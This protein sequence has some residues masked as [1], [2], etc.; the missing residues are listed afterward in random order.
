MSSKKPR[1]SNRERRRGGAPTPRASKRRCTATRA[2][3]VAEDEAAV[4]DDETAVDD[5][6]SDA[7]DAACNDADATEATADASA[8][9]E[10]DELEEKE[11]ASSG[12]RSL[13]ACGREWLESSSH[14]TC[15]SRARAMWDVHGV[16]SGCGGFEA[17]LGSVLTFAGEDARG[18][19]AAAGAMRAEARSLRDRAA[20]L[21]YFA[22]VIDSETRSH[23]GLEEEAV[24][25]ALRF[26]PR[27]LAACPELR[28]PGASAH[29]LF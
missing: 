19:K 14:A 12:T 18:A 20:G 1:A 4:D 28:V 17:Q 23:G 10:V 7:A 22:R 6:D 3:A 9:C 29:T 25:S 26:A 11:E 13:A 21:E 24:P 16:D 8:D 27:E 5:G 2:A 15:P